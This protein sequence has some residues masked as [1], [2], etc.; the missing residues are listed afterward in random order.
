MMEF[1]AGHDDFLDAVAMCFSLLQPLYAAAAAK[2]VDRSA[3]DGSYYESEA[4]E[5][6]GL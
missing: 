4:G 5:T 1:P 2:E 6:G 3:E